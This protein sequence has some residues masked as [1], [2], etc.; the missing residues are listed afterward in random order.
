MLTTDFKPT[1]GHIWLRTSSATSATEYVDSRSDKSKYWTQIGY[2]PQFDAL[3]DELTPADHIRLFARLKG[4]AR[5]HEPALCYSLL[6]RLDLLQYENKPVGALSLGNK[7]KLRYQR[8][9]QESL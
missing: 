2:C 4:I 5:T 1:R 6:K 7:R 3:Y 9:Q 8:I